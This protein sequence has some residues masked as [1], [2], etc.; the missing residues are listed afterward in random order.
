MSIQAA[1]PIIPVIMCGGAGTRLWP[2]SRETMPKQFIQLLGQESTF[3]ATLRRVSNPAVFGK[4]VIIAGNDVRFI[5]AEQ[6]QQVGMEA[7]IVLEPARRDSAAAVAV[8][9]ETVARRDP[10]GIALVLAADHVVS[11]PAAFVAACSL[12]AA[13]A[14][15]GYV[16]TLG[17]TPSAPSTAYGYIRPGRRIEGTECSEVARFV[18]KPD[19]ATAKGYLNE[20]YLWNSGNFLFAAKTMVAELEAHV[21]EIAAAAREALDKASRDLDFVRLDEKAFMKSPKTSIDYA[22]ME[23]TTRAGVLP[24]D[25]GWSDVGTWGALW[26][27]SQRD[28]SGN[29]VM[30]HATLVNTRDSLVH[31]ED[32]K[33]GVVGLDNVVVVATKD[34]VL[35]TSRERS[36]EVKE[37]VAQLKAANAPEAEAHLRVHR[38]WGWYERIE[39]GPRFQVKRIMV[40]S[41]ARLSLQKH[42]HRAEHWVVVRGTAEVT[43]DERCWLMQENEAAYLP[44]GSVHRLANPGRIPLEIIEVQVGS[45]T[46]EDDIIRIEDVYGRS[47]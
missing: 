9:A 19:L 33:T 28:E 16:M 18:E 10:R 1:S 21:P 31:S 7:E 17:I 5:V 35:V 40:K 27:V 25:C 12:A 43:V 6:L 46:G 23:K 30:G 24:V 32:L 11:D 2:A 29:V 15:K 22:V 47:I 36:G 41:G 39:I 38:P 42:M 44:L 45:Y 26:E 37:L 13:G 14:A 4:P 8:A 3:Q 34:A 20:G